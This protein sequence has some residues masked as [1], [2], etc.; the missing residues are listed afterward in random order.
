[1]NNFKIQHKNKTYI[2]K[3]ENV[4]NI[5]RILEDKE[6][7]DTTPH[8]LIKLMKKFKLYDKLFFQNINKI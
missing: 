6:I 7:K 4:I 5:L 1:M 8:K 2:F 3:K